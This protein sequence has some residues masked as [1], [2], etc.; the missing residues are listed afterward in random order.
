MAKIKIE[1]SNR[2]IA[3]FQ[4]TPTSAAALPTLQIGAMVE[5]GFNALT[6]PIVDA[7]KLTKKQE[8]KNSLRKLKLATYPKISEALGKYKNETDIGKLTNFISDLD[9]KKFADLIKDQNKDV[10]QSFNDYLADTVDKNY[11]NLYSKIILNHTE[12]SYANDLDDLMVWDKMEASDDVKTRLYGAGQKSI[13]FNNPSNKDR[14][15]AKEWKQQQEDSKKRT[16]TF[17]LAF[18]T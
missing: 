6:K 18:R 8:D 1:R 2:Q 10:K 17:Q 5:Q 14:Y 11:D 16:L 13:Y 7:A 9:P 4:G 12:Q 15:G 3:Q